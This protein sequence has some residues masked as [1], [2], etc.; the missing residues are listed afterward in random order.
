MS[1]LSLLGIKGINLPIGKEKS[2]VAPIET[3]VSGW[4]GRSRGM[5]K[6]P[7]QEVERGDLDDGCFIKLKGYSGTFKIEKRVEA[8]DGFYH[9]KLVRE[10]VPK[11]Y[12]G[13]IPKLDTFSA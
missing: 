5:L 3:Y 11:S 12:E 10:N 8:W 2:V 13:R 4:R 7:N 1:L 6:R 9:M